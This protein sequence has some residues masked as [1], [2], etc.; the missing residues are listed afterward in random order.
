M[1]KDPSNH[2]HSRLVLFSAE[3]EGEDDAEELR[4]IRS[5]KFRAGTD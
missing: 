1:F 2:P 5:S 4:S 3:N